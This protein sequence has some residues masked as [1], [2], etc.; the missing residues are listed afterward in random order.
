M[1]EIEMIIR[2]LKIVQE[3]TLEI[4]HEIILEKHKVDLQE[5]LNL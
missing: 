2:T 1:I 4:V 5:K 3:I